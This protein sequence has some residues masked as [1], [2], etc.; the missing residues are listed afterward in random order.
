MV[1]GATGLL[2]RAVT[3]YLRDSGLNVTGTGHTRVGGR[4]TVPLDARDPSAVDA[5]L[6]TI[7]PGLVINAAG[8]RR[9]EHW[10]TD[11]LHEVNVH[12]ASNIARSCRTFAAWLVHISSDYVFDGTCPPYSPDAPR[13]PLNVYGATKVRAEDEV[14]GRLPEATVLRLPVLYGMVERLDESNMTSLLPL[15]LNGVESA[16]DDWAIRYPTLTVDVAR[17]LAGALAHHDHL[18]GVTCHWSA[19][20]G[21]TKYGMAC[22]VGAVLGVST[23]HLIPDRQA[24]MTRP[25]DALLDCSLLEGL[26]LGIRTPLDEAL[27]AILSAVVTG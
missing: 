17:V 5:L 19:M 2:G 15:V 10:D 12:A 3:K 13:R 16:V 14:L 6:D 7:K 24:S 25:R 18:S 26:G 9:P 1:I 20:E 11:V 27:T 4:D 8:E 22:R 23:D 21:L